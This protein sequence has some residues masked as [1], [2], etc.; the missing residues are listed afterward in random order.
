MRLLLNGTVV[1]ESM[2]FS[3]ADVDIKD[4]DLY[5][6]VKDLKKGKH[7]ISIEACIDKAYNAGDST[8]FLPYYDP[9][10]IEG[11]ADSPI[12]AKLWLEGKIAHQ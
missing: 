7:S 2:S 6:K 4:V 8:L 9:S 5:G 1:G 12:T 10:L 11:R 3:C